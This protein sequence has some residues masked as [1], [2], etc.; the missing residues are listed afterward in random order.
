M[1]TPKIGP[2]ASVALQNSIP[3]PATPSPKIPATFRTTPHDLPFSPSALLAPKAFDSALR[4]KINEALRKQ[5]LLFDPSLFD[6]TRAAETGLDPVLYAQ[7]WQQWSSDVLDQVNPMYAA[8]KPGQAVFMTLWHP[9]TYGGI[10]H[11]SLVILGKTDQGP[12]A[13][14]LNHENIPLPASKRAAQPYDSK[15]G[16]M[17]NSVGL[18]VD[19]YDSRSE[20]EAVTQEKMPM[21]N[22]PLMRSLRKAGFPS[23]AYQTI[24]DFEAACRYI[25]QCVDITKEAVRRG[26]FDDFSYTPYESEY[27]DPNQYG[28]SPY[29]NILPR[30]DNQWGLNHCLILTLEAYFSGQKI[31]LKPLPPGCGRLESFGQLLFEHGLLASTAIVPESELPPPGI[32]AFR[33]FGTSLALNPRARPPFATPG[34]LLKLFKENG[35]SLEQYQKA[36]GFLEFLQAKLLSAKL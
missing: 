5:V 1:K 23:V 25:D 18:A 29:P 30:G 31:V 10:T 4:K 2:G 27:L 20:F 33:T 36:M 21:S 28:K 14:M 16:R 35:L 22:L 6:G 17:P 34:S 15:T 32:G 12:V 3:G 9:N 26:K 8:L 13:R 19:R 24:E 11:A 7:K